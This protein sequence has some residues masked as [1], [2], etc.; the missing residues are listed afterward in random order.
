MRRSNTVH[1]VDWATGIG[2][3]AWP[4][5]ACRVGVAGWELDALQPTRHDVT[6]GRCLRQVKRHKT[7][8]LATTEIPGQ[9][10]LDLIR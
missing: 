5:P 1:V 2:G 10:A 3:I 9:L 6:C 4:V 7:P 8:D